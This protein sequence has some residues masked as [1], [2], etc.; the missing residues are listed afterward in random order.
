VE[1]AEALM[2]DAAGCWKGS[3]RP[4]D[5]RRIVLDMLPGLLEGEGRT[6]DA[7]RWRRTLETTTP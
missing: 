4:D 2:I 7:A 5:V 6:D 1:K 3:E